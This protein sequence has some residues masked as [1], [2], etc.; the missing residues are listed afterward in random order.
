VNNTHTT[1]DHIILL[2][3]TLGINRRNTN[4]T[5]HMSLMI[6]MEQAALNPSTVVIIS[7]LQI[8]TSKYSQ[9]S[10]DENYA[11]KEGTVHFS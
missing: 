2:L 7:T 8:F 11:L 10:Q 6:F 9:H 1:T 5:G 4:R 3:N